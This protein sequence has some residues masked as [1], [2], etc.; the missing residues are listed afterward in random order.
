MVSG[1][2]LSRVTLPSSDVT[3]T[4]GVTVTSGVRVAT[5]NYGKNKGRPLSFIDER[6]VVVILV[7]S[8]HIFMPNIFI[9]SSKRDQ[10][11]KGGTNIGNFPVGNACD[12]L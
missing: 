5:G 10:F 9:G 2:A 12:S 11:V 3:V 6:T 4:T 7:N 8:K 1:K